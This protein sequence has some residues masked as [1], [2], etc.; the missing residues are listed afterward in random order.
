MLFGENREGKEFVSLVLLLLEAYYQ[1]TLVKAQIGIS[2]AYL[3]C[4]CI[5]IKI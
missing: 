2:Q 4:E 3:L 1:L 5:P